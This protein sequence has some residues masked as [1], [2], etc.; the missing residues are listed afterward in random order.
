[1]K[2]DESGVKIDQEK[3]KNNSMKGGRKKYRKKAKKKNR[4]E[5]EGRIKRK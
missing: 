1:M 2:E 3:N 4:H 5:N